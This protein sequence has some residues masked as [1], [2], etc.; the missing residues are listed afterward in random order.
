MNATMRPYY[1]LTN[2]GRALRLRQL[3]LAAL[4]DYDLVVRRVRLLSNSFNA[5]FRVDTAD[6]KYVLRV[7]RPT[8]TEHGLPRLHSEMLWLAALR[9]DTDLQVPAPLATR[10]GAYVT[11]AQVAAVPEPRHCVVFSWLPGRDFDEQ[12]SPATMEQ[13]GALAAQLHCHAAAWTSPAGFAVG[14][15]AT[16]FPFEPLIMFDAAYAE[17]LPPA[18]RA[19]F[20]VTV[21]RI[22]AAIDRLQASA[23]PHVIHADLHRWNAKIYRGRILP[24]D[25][26]EILWGW[27][28]QDIGISLYYL[29]GE[30]DY[31]AWRA[32]FERG[33]ERVAP[34]PEAYPGEIDL[35]IAARG[36]MLAN[37]LLTDVDPEWRAQTPRYFEKTEHRLRALLEGGEPFN[38]RYW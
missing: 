25:F 20:M 36:L 17:L 5:I 32:A 19:L 8:E 18:R 10:Q 27:P 16:P 37:G 7:C 3:A 2:R 11:T 34:W 9:R 31:P 14:R 6:G 1:S 26:Q 35:F 15:Y 23:P 24:F 22:Q 12:I 21:E 4:A 33:Y 28:V 30:A 38:L 29:Y 13:F